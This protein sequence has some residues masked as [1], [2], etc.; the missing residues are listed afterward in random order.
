M[1]ILIKQ[2]IEQFASDKT[3]TKEDK[4]L[5]INNFLKKYISSDKIYIVSKDAN[6]AYTG[7]IYLSK[8]SFKKTDEGYLI[9]ILDN[10]INYFIIL[11]ELGHYL[12]LNKNLN[13]IKKFEETK[14]FEG[15]FDIIIKEEIFADKF[16]SLNYYKLFGK[17]F[18]S[19]QTFN[20]PF[21]LENYKKM[22][23]IIY[24]KYIEQIGDGNW[25]S[26]LIN[27]FG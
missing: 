27:M 8:N 4:D 12:H 10:P 19:P 6:F 17:T 13:I 9:P 21:Y 25:E 5:L 1:K 24:K 20:I 2:I 18:K 14:D 26:F 23:K 3:E 22:I 7:G 15:F 16:S 11:H